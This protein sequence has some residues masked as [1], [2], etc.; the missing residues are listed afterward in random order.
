MLLPLGAGCPD[1]RPL[2]LPQA[3]PVEIGVYKARVTREDGRSRRFRLLLY[4]EAPDRLHAE[5]VAP[6]GG[7]QL[8]VDGNASRLSIA[9]VRDKLAFAGEPTGSDLERIVGSPVSPAE[10]VRALLEGAP[11]SDAGI[12]VERTGEGGL[13]TTFSIRSG[14]H[15][16]ELE[17]R[18]TDR[19]TPKGGLLA[20][21]EP[22]D[23][24]ETYPLSDLVWDWFA[25]E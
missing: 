21:G 9:L 4:A 18:R 12:T 15:R 11:P 14:G 19:T 13:P 17:L 3:E 22:P 7:T 20:S 5:A 10:L 1:R 23:G 2:Q 16:L 6:V 8:I 24:F 25:S